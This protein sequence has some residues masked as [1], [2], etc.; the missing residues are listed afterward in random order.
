MLALR[1]TRRGWVKRLK[2]KGRGT[3]ERGPPEKA[4]PCSL[5]VSLRPWGTQQQALQLDSDRCSVVRL[6]SPVKPTVAWA[7]K[8][9]VDENGRG[10]QWKWRRGGDE[11]LCLLAPSAND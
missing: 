5:A 4:V 2:G 7:G 11:E 6:R 10:A 3:Q 8:R 9:V 1:E